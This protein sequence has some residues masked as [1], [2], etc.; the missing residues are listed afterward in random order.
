M[1]HLPQKAGS[2]VRAGTVDRTSTLHQDDDEAG[3]VESPPGGGNRLSRPRLMRFSEVRDLTGLSR[4]T[5]WR[6]E[7]ASAFPRRVRVS[8]NAVAWSEEEIL[9]WIHRKLT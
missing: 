5:I 2:T 3:Q 6:L 8:P 7:R 1:S 9:N 4:S